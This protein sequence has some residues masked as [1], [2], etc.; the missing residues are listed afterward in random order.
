MLKINIISC[1]TGARV[2]KVMDDIM[3]LGLTSPVCAKIGQKVAFSRRL[4]TK[5]RL[6]GYGEIKSGQKY[7]LNDN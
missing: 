5:F 3:I 6:I 7:E 2:I 4:N 1:E